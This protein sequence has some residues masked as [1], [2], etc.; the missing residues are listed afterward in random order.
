MA[1]LPPESYHFEGFLTG[2]GRHN[3]NP[4]LVLCSVEA[5]VDSEFHEK[6]TGRGDVE[7]RF[8]I[9]RIVREDAMRRQVLD[10]SFEVSPPS[11]NGAI[12]VLSNTRNVEWGQFVETCFK[13]AQGRFFDRFP[14]ELMPQPL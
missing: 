8:T 12:N 6:H 10:Y 13:L 7:L 5:P 4:G 11:V 14:Q 3:A 1:F 9:T 2:A